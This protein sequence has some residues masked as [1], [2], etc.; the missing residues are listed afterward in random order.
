[1]KKFILFTLLLG[2][3]AP[4]SGIEVCYVENGVAICGT[5]QI[6]LEDCEPINSEDVVCTIERRDDQDTPYPYTNYTTVIETCTDGSV[7]VWTEIHCVGDTYL[8]G[9]RCVPCDC[10]Q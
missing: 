7:S 9:V 10:N 8:E 4:K 1:M 5:K 6:Q 3:C 2:S